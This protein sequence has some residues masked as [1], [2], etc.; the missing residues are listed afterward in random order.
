MSATDSGA[1]SKSSTSK[2]NCCITSAGGGREQSNFSCPPDW[3]STITIASTWS[4]PSTGACRYFATT[5][6]RNRPTG[7]SNHEAAPV[8]GSRV[9]RRPELCPGT[10]AHWRY[11]AHAQFELSEWRFRLFAGKPWVHV[12]TCSAQ[13]LG[14][15]H[16]TVEPKAFAEVVCALH[17]HHRPY[18]GEHAAYAGYWQ[19]PLLELP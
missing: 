9:D 2:D 1:W 17:Q 3:R 6:S 14:R 7:G 4:I 19:Q 8:S 15:Q 10:A 5:A 16:A 13:W 18:P 11:A 12:L